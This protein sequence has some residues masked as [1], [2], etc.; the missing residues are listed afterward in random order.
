[1]EMETIKTPSLIVDF[2]RM[3]RNS[4]N[5][6]NRAKELNVNLRPHVKTHRCLEIAKIQ[7]ENTFGGIMVSTLSEAQFFSKNG[8]SDITYGVPIERGKFAEAIE[9]AQK[10][11]KFSLLTDDAETVELLNEKAKSENTKLNVFVKID[12]GYHRCG[13]EPHT[14]EAFEIPQKISDSSNLNFAGILTHAGHSYHA[15]SPEKLLEVA[16]TERDMMRRSRAKNFAE[17]A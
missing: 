11:G 12:V 5:V 6:S 15:D 1:M 14:K 7:T 16:R 3:K 10:T 9:I 13:I 17:K 4:E 8:F 2:E